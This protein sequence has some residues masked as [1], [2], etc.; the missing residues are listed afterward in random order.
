M[1]LSPQTNQLNDFY[2]YLVNA[3]NYI[4]T[5][6]NNK[7]ITSGQS[8]NSK[9]KTNTNV[10]VKLRHYINLLTK[11]NFNLSTSYYDFFQFKKSNKYL[12]KMEKAT[13]LLKLAFLAKGCLISKPIF[14]ILYPQ[15]NILEEENEINLS[16]FKKTKKNFYKPKIIIHLFYYIKTNIN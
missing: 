3:L 6:K 7:L 5:N 10:N 2:F 13:E 16:E 4:N 11:Y 1:F 9:D 12:F 15:I 8:I 14:N